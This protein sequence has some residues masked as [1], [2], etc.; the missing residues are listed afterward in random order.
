[1]IELPP[2]CTLAEARSSIGAA[3]ALW[4]TPSVRGKLADQRL[5]PLIDRPAFLQEGGWLVVA[6]GGT[7]IDEAKL[8]RQTYPAGKLAALPTIW[9]SGAE[10]SPIAVVNEANHKR[11]YLNSRLRPD[12]IIEH[13]E[14]AVSLPGDRIFAACGDT[15]AHALEGFLSP[16][17][18]Q[19]LRQDLA[20]LL[21][22]LLVLPLAHHPEW[23]HVSALAA[24][25][26]AR[27]SV[28]LIH[29]LAHTLEPM[30]R[31]PS[32]GH[33]KLCA[34]FLLPVF[35]FNRTTSTKPG[36]LLAQ[37]FITLDSIDTRLREFF[38]PPAYATLLPFLADHW[39]SVIRD[40]CSRTNC[41]MVRPAD[42]EFFLEFTP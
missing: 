35:R 21:R 9:G 31:D 14:L 13:P 27:S 19:E 26:Q 30:L 28:G 36:E 41:S 20:D 12:L 10:A 39:T 24:A 33:A 5:W 11:I 22:R 7:M 3:A 1:M 15:W 32:W 42:R 16:L 18:S 17:A 29:G 37:H 40:R 8:F 23:F 6:G 25:G 2:R 34:T 4:A 38:D